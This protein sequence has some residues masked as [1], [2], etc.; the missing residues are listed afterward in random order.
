MMVLLSVKKKYC[1]LILQ[2]TKQFEFRKRLPNA[3]QKGDQIALYCTQ[4]TSMVV[5]YVD[6]ADVIQSTPQTLWKRTSFAAGIDHKYFSEYFDVSYLANAIQIGNIHK[7]KKPLSLSSLRGNATP[8]QS[9]LYLSDEEAARVRENA[10]IVKRNITVFIGGVHGVGKTTFLDGM[11]KP[12]GF[13]TF[14]A[15]D[16]IKSH[17]Q[18]IRKDK[19]VSDIAGN[20]KGLIVESSK[21]AARHRLYALDGHF[22]LLSNERK[23]QPIPIEVFVSLKPD[24][25]ILL[26]D[27]CE[28]IQMRLMLRDGTKW[29]K[30]LINS[31]LREEERQ[32]ARVAESLKIPLLR[33][34]TTNTLSWTR[35]K[36]FVGD[37]IQRKFNVSINIKSRE[38]S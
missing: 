35:I 6:V 20:Q 23:V 24:C 10:L 27:S 4:P 33:V 7:L 9:F 12:L 30:A 32:A 37:A 34:P 14:S 36:A 31:F 13:A 29:S 3:L 25:M 5:A 26:S 17:K 16:L 21:K 2:G 38:F 28:Q 18:M 19:T 1:D 22:T 11:L 8:P 15:S